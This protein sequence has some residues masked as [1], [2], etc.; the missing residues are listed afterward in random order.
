LEGRYY[1]NVSDTKT[2]NI[3]SVSIYEHRVSRMGWGF[4]EDA[5]LAEIHYRGV[6]NEPPED[7]LKGMIG[8]GRARA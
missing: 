5:K 1:L 7:L 3:A 8:A 4:L 2:P 6:L